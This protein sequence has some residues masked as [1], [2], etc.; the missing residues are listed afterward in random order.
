MSQKEQWVWLLVNK[1]HSEIDK[2]PTDF[3]RK[4]FC[5]KDHQP[6]LERTDSETLNGP[7]PSNCLWTGGELRRAA[8]ASGR[9][10]SLGTHFQVKKNDGRR[11]S[12]RAGPGAPDNKT[13][14]L[15]PGREISAKSKRILKTP[16][17][18]ILKLLQPALYLLCLPFLFCLDVMFYCSYPVFVPLLDPGCVGNIT[19]PDIRTIAYHFSWWRLLV[20]PISQRPCTVSLMPLAN[21]N[22]GLSH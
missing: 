15:I 9:L 22:F 4:L 16:D 3:S 19:G 1:V 6:G 11:L 7:W 2:K 17:G 20:L 21:G 8:Q 5:R 18:G 13:W 12:Q 10:F 14:E